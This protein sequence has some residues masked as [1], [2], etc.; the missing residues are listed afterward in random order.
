VEPV[1]KPKK[2][3]PIVKSTWFIFRKTKKSSS[4][5]NIVLKKKHALLLKALKNTVKFQT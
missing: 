2:K 3:V 5:L 1:Q 4:Q